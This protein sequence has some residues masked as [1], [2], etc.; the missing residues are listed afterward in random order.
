MNKK[1]GLLI[2]V[3]AALS[4]VLGIG[5]YVKNQRQIKEVSHT[6]AEMLDAADKNIKYGA[7]GQPLVMSY[8]RQNEYYALED[9]K[10]DARS[11][12]SKMPKGSLEVTVHSV[13]YY[14]DADT[15][16]NSLVQN[17]YDQN[18]KEAK[19]FMRGLGQADKLGALVARLTVTNKDATFYTEFGDQ[20]FLLTSLNFTLY[21]KNRSKFVTP[22]PD[23]Q[24]IVV[25]GLKDGKAKDRGYI[26]FE[27][28]DT[29]EFI[30]VAL[31]R[32][33]ANESSSFS[34]LPNEL[35]IGLTIELPDACVRFDKS[36]IS[37]K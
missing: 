6:Q 25:G 8:D 35:L 37:L 13:E 12:T 10:P 33:P 14:N 1:I 16:T 5:F 21:D 15:F 31:D 26:P 20:Y 9:K 28:G 18:L 23:T 29:K 11:A 27:I 30:L 19:D 34:S 22:F 36:E 17:Q 4:L 7:I 3:L 2:S 32:Y 24:Y